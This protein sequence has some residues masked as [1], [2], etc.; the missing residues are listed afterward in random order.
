MKFRQNL[1]VLTLAMAMI[2]AAG[3]GGAKDN[4]QDTHEHH[5]HMQ[6]QQHA[7][8]M[9]HQDHAQHMEHTG[10]ASAEGEDPH[11]H[12]RAMMK[13]PAGAAKSAN[14]DLRDR[15]LLN[16]DGT[17]VGFVSDVIG[18]NIVVMDFIY[19]TCTTICPVLTAVMGQVQE[20]VGDGLGEDVALVS[21][22][23]D[24]TR[25][26]PQRLKAY[27]VSH[28]AN[29]GWSWITGPKSAVDDVLTGLGAF[30]PNFCLLYTSDAAD[31][32]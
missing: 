16:Q 11:A 18:D 12:H 17:Q 4:D 28:G 7:E 24:P 26:N 20:R 27:A 1:S 29:P 13:Q 30:S 19:T 3:S 32:N 8:H 23:V 25:D 2:L 6:H 14:V 31:D 21:V 5:Q 9:Q 10:S 22:T 15:Q